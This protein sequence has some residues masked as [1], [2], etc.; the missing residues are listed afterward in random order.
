MDQLSG[1]NSDADW[2]DE[3]TIRDAIESLSRR[4]KKILGLRFFEGR[5]QTEVSGVIGISQAQV[6][7]LEKGALHK[8]QQSL[9]V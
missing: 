3:I 6:S 4:E 2:I 8:I 7:R 1:G 5:T 9:K